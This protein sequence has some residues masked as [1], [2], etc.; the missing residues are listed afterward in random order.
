MKYRV[1]STR[2]PKILAVASTFAIVA[3]FATAADARGPK[4]SVDVE[5][6]CGD[7]AAVD[8]LTGEVFTTN[9]AVRLTDVSDDNGPV[10]AT[11]GMLTVE[12]EAA[13]PQGRGRPAQVSFGTM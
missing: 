5:A 11:V 9:V 8:P 3:G 13:V 1:S 7:P 2:N 10:G 6:Y 12:C 4:L